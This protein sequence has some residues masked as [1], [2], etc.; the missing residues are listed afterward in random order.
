MTLNQAAQH[1]VSVAVTA[2]ES[3]GKL[4][5]WAS[6]IVRTVGWVNI[7]H[8][9]N[10]TRYMRPKPILAD[11]RSARLR[12]SQFGRHQPGP[13]PHF[14]SAVNTGSGAA[15]RYCS[16]ATKHRGQNAIAIMPFTGMQSISS[17][18]PS[19]GQTGA[20]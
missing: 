13:A 17:S 9:K 3:V 10:Q 18:V 4:R 12:A 6:G 8:D 20:R 11:R 5:T 19:T 14:C 2:A 1:V 16:R 15:L 7:L